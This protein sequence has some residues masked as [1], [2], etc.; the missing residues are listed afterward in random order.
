MSR[1]LLRWRSFP[2][3]VEHESIVINGN[4]HSVCVAVQMGWLKP[5]NSC[6]PGRDLEFY[7]KEGKMARVW[8]AA[9]VCTA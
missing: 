2:I 8:A 1:L 9:L 3:L 6:M 5:T 4:F 7:V